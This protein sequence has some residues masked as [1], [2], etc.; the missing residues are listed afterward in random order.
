MAGFGEA[1][2]PHDILSDEDKWLKYF[3]KTQLLGISIFA[4]IGFFL[5]RVFATI[6]LS[7]VGVGIMLIIVLIGA[8]IMMV[9]VPIKNYLMGGGL[10]LWEVVI[11]LIYRKATKCTYV[12]NLT[13]DESWGD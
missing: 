2:V 11:L 5:F 6:G 10:Y 3:T 8:A 13:E 4:V 9:T 12:K 1:R 7:M